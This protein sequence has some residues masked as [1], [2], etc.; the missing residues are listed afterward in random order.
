MAESEDAKELFQSIVDILGFQDIKN[1][2]E[3]KRENEQKKLRDYLKKHP[4]LN[5]AG[6]RAVSGCGKSSYTSN[7]QIAPFD[8][9]NWKYVEIKDKDKRF[10]A[11]ISLNMPDK[12]P[13]SGNFHALYDR[14]GLIIKEKDSDKHFVHADIVIHTDI[15]LPFDEAAMEEIARI[16]IE[17][18]NIFNKSNEAL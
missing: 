5:K 17:Q 15:D 9:S 11:V 16:V 10:S 7:R 2:Y 13:K 14:V 6:L 3:Q 8:L 4:A 12:D 18:F 1:A